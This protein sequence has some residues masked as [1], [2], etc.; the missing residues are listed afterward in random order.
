VALA[1]CQ[2]L[3]A[4]VLCTT[5]TELLLCE[6]HASAPSTAAIAAASVNVLL[7]FVLSLLLQLVEAGDFPGALLLARS[8]LTPLADVHPELLPCLKASMTLLLPRP[9]AGGS[10]GSNGSSSSAVLGQKLWDVLLPLLQSSVGIEPPGL[11]SLVQVGVR[12]G[13]SFQGGR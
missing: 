4:G 1:S 2:W 12:E 11:V 6:G 13:I 7:L 5:G 10:S 3:P 9:A 8:Q